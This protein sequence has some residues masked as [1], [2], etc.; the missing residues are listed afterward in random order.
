MSIYSYKLAH[1]Q[2]VINCLYSVAH[3]C[4]SEATLA[5]NLGVLHFD[6]I[7]SYNSLTTLVISFFCFDTNKSALS[8]ETI[9][10]NKCF[11]PKIRKCNKVWVSPYVM[12]SSGNY[13]LGNLLLSHISN[14]VARNNTWISVVWKVVQKV[15]KG[16]TDILFVARCRR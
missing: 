6:D 3:L 1:A 15:L 13:F 5:H 9:G 2:V 11:S 10:T 8:N 14:Y 4:T 7:K 12:F 16:A